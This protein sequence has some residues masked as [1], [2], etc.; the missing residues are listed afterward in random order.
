MGT[1]SFPVLR[2]LFLFLLVLQ[3][4][5]FTFEMFCSGCGT[6]CLVN[7]K[8]CDHCGKQLSG[9]QGS[10]H[11]ASNTVSGGQNMTGNSEDTNMSFESFR[12]RKQ[13]ERSKFF[14]SSGKS[15][16]KKSKRRSQMLT[17]MWALC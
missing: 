10:S 16:A 11:T 14:K 9:I 3:K 15:K 7:S 2:T 4:V 6:A 13:D 8:F 12:A 1:T 5:T 17:S